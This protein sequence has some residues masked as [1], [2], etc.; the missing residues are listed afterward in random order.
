MNAK[1]PDAA[2]AARIREA[3]ANNEPPTGELFVTSNTEGAERIFTNTRWRDI[4]AAA[5]S[6]HGFSAAFMS[7]EAFAYF[8]PAFMLASLT[9]PGL[10][11]TLLNAL[12]PP[13]SDVSRPKFAAW[14]NLL[15]Q[16]QKR[17]VVDFVEHCEGEGAIFPDASLQALRGLT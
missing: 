17:A 6:F 15:S 16:S 9:D 4:D 8:L 3:F 14:W 10:R 12:L 2:L 1:P 11:D 5:L 7:G 13:K